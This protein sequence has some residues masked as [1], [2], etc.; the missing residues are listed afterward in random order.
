MSDFDN[1]LTR[2]ATTVFM[3]PR[4]FGGTLVIDGRPVTAM[5]DDEARPGGTGRNSGVDEAMY[6]INVESRVLLALAAELPRPTPGQE[7]LVAGAYWTVGPVDDCHGLYEI[8]LSRN[9]S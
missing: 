1:M 8:S 3:N 4:K 7:L 2:H 6:G 5:W 9:L